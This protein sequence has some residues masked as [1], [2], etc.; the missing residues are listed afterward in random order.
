V[1]F[2]TYGTPIAGK[3]PTEEVEMASFFNKVGEITKHWD[4]PYCFQ[5]EAIQK[6][7]TRPARDIMREI[8]LGVEG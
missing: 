4:R 6:H 5:L 8:G 7:L 2:K 3:C 1:P